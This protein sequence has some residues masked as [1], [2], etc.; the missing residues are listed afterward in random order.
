VFD[1]F[2]HGLDRSQ[3]IRFVDS[4]ELRYGHGLEGLEAVYAGIVDQDI[5]A[6]KCL[7]GLREK[8]AHVFGFGDVGAD[9]DGLA[10]ARRDGGN[11]VSVCRWPMDRQRFLVFSCPLK[12]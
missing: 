4:S 3:N 10:A 9:R 6:A 2:L 8:A 5:K 1:G 11:N 7:D 12:V